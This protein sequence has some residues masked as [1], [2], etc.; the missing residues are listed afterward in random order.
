M[1]DSLTYIW[2]KKFYAKIKSKK[3]NRSFFWKDNKTLLKNVLLESQAPWEQLRLPET[4]SQSCH[5][6]FS[7]IRAAPINLSTQ[8]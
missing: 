8:Y 3:S 7:A 4:F 6:Y 2:P 5:Y 1:I